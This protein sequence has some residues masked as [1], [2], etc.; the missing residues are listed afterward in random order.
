MEKQNK[1]NRI[2]GV[3]V[4]AI[5]MAGCCPCRHVAEDNQCKDSI[6]VEYR[7]KV[8]YIPDT[9]YVD[10]PKQT[11]EKVTKDS[12]SHLENDYSISDAIMHADGTLSHTLM[13]KPQRKAIETQKAI[14]EKDSVVYRDKWNKVTI[15]QEVEKRLT[16]WQKL[17][18]WG[19]RLF[20]LIIMFHFIVAVIWM[21]KKSK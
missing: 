20:F 2:L 3:I 10:I 13:T 15:T 4:I 1:L 21:T 9:I 11:A 18:I 12:V 7:E 19:G 6:R 5:V 14:V 16:K 17:Q 8:T